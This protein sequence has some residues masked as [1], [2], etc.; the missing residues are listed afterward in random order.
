MNQHMTSPQKDVTRINK[1]FLSITARD[2]AINRINHAV[3]SP[4]STDGNPARATTLMVSLLNT[5]PSDPKTQQTLNKALSSLQRASILLLGGRKKLAYIHRIHTCTALLKQAANQDIL[6][7]PLAQIIE[8]HL[9]RALSDYAR[10]SFTHKGE[11]QAALN[12]VLNPTIL[13]TE[14]HIYDNLKPST[15]RVVMAL[16]NT[17]TSADNVLKARLYLEN[18]AQQILNINHPNIKDDVQTWINTRQNPARRSPSL[19]SKIKS[20]APQ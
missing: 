5:H 18:D 3:S 14:T 12:Y 7:T 10:T 15:S 2:A 13:D 16:L 20:L 1:A 11:P 8:K 17:I 9:I 4:Y 6:D 19:L